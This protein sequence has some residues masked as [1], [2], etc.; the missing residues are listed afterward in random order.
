MCAAASPP[1]AAAGPPPPGEEPAARCRHAARRGRIHPA[2]PLIN[3]WS[4][5][6]SRGST[7]VVT[8]ARLPSFLSVVA[9][10]AHAL[11]VARG[12]SRMP[13]GLDGYGVGTLVFGVASAACACRAARTGALP[14]REREAYLVAVAV[15]VL[16]IDWVNAATPGTVRLWGCQVLVIDTCLVWDVDRRVTQGIV[17]GTVVWLAVCASEAAQRWGL[18]D[19]TR[20]TCAAPP[21]A[22]GPVS[23]VLGLM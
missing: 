7:A 19:V 4:Y 22:V 9:F 18:F 1:R 2:T 17:C 11:H 12:S 3:A 15:C 21:C 13:A 6:R 16:L 5:R 14:R 8:N 23:G 20:T 10:S